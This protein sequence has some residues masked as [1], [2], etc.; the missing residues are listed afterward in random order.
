MKFKKI[1]SIILSISLVSLIGNNISF[2]QDIVESYTLDE[3]I[4]RTLEMNDNLKTLEL[5]KAQVDEGLRMSKSASSMS[6]YILSQ[7]QDYIQMYEIGAPHI[8]K[9]KTMTMEEVTLTYTAVFKAIMNPFTSETALEKLLEEEKYIQYIF[10]FGLEEPSLSDREKYEKY[11]QNIQLTALNGEYESE[12]FY[13]IL[14]QTRATVEGSI[15]Y[16]Y[17]NYNDLKENIRLQNNLL[18][19]YKKNLDDLENKY[20]KGLISKIDYLDFKDQHDIQKKNIV[21]LNLQ[22]ENLEYTLKNQMQIDMDKNIDFIRNLTESKDYSLLNKDEFIDSAKEN[23]ADYINAKLDL[24]YKNS[25]KS[26]YEK[27]IPYNTRDK[28]DILSDLKIFE[29]QYFK[30]SQELESNVLY[31]LEEIYQKE[32]DLEI[33]NLAFE[34]TKNNYLNAKKQYDLGLINYTQLLGVE[35]QYITDSISKTIAD[36]SLFNSKEKFRLLIENGVRY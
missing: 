18:A 34:L 32:V 21:T 10:M 5:N 36:R 24:N 28:H 16:L 11:I 7:Y 20:N 4:E 1:A 35:S 14:D 27:Y 25:E 31:G 6:K 8:Q 13:N 26:L 2:S 23:S 15:T 33:K 12:K 9:Y 29:S 30:I 19:Y 3:V 17:I 22:L